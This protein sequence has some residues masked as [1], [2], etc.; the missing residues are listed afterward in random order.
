MQRGFIRAETVSYNDLTTL[1]G[2]AAARAA[3][4]VRD[5][6]KNYIVQDGDIFIFK[7]SV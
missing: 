7:F 5:E 3:G 1:G 4:K 6:G 2:Y